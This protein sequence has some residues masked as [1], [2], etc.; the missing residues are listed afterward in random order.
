MNLYRPS[1]SYYTEFTTQRFDTGAATNGDSLPT[2]TATKNGTDD[3]AFTLTVAN[4]DT[5]R[6]KISGTVPAGYAANDVVQ[7]SVAATVNSVSGKG[8][9]DQFRVIA[10]GANI[11]VVNASTNKVLL[12]STDVSGKIAATVA[13]GDSV[14]CAATKAASIIRQATAQGGGTNYITLDASASSTNNFYRFNRVVI[15]SGLGV[16]QQG[17]ILDY[18]GSTQVATIDHTWSTTPDAT[19]IFA[20]LNYQRELIVLASGIAQAGAPATITLSTT[21]GAPNNGLRGALIHIR[22]G[23]GS[24]QTR[25]IISNVNSTKI[26]TIDKTWDT[27]PDSTSVYYIIDV[28]NYVT[29]GMIDSGVTI[30]TVTTLT[31]APTGMSTLTTADLYTGGKLF[32]GT[33]GSIKLGSITSTAQPI[34][35]G[36][37]L[38]NS[39]YKLF[40]GTDGSVKIGSAT[41]TVLP[42][43]GGT[44]LTDATKKLFSGSDGSM[45]LGVSTSTSIAAIQSGLATPTNITAGTITTVTNLTNP[46][47]NM[48]VE[49]GGALAGLVTTVGVAG[50]GL[51]ALGDTRL[52]DIA[53]ILT[54]VNGLQVLPKNV[55]C[56]NF[57]VKMVLTSDHSTPATGKTVSGFISKDGGAFVALSTPTCTEIGLGAYKVNITQSE[58]NADFILLAFTASACDQRMFGIKTQA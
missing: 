6:Y 27:Q 25:T 21:D 55:A 39:A 16:G 52:S 57:P 46:P 20:I 26:A 37:V 49:T 36:T 34:L 23:T 35:G 3:G 51:T 28:G 54:V 56:P 38:A 24:G 22:G 50:A 17:I 2:A 13:A 15:V 43:I 14:D 12:T 1:D 19:S 29:N 4:I 53:T 48:A 7:I 58:M 44:V 41:T 33:D 9:V 5:G 40:T 31:N 11:P 8:V 42:I 10:S 18:V 32:T 30:P 45:K 47:T